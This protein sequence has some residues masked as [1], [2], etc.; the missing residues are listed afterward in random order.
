MWF[1]VPTMGA[2]TAE[3]LP[4][5]ERNLAAIG[6]RGVP[7]PTY[8]RHE[9]P[10][11]IAHIGVGGFHRAHLAVYTDEVAHGGGDWGIRGIGLLPTDAAMA[12]A[13]EPQDCL[14]SLVLKGAGTPTTSIIGSIVDYCHAA[15]R[16]DDAVELLADPVVAIVSLT[17]T[18]AGY[19]AAG[20]ASFGVIA[21]ALDRR[22]RNGDGG[23][24]VLSCDN[25]PG[26]G[27]VARRAL[28]TAA[29]RIG[30]LVGWVEERCS[31][32]N[33]MVDR[34]T[35]VT[36]DDDR[37][38]LLERE[39][40][41][42]RWPV[43]AEPFRQWV[44]EDDFVAGRPEWERAGALF[45]TDV[46]AW[47]LYKLRILNA[48]HSC[49]AY[50][51]ALAGLTFVDEA[52]A[53]PTVHAYVAKLLYDEAVPALVPIHGHPRV[54]YVSTVL[55]R[56]T[57]PGVRDQIARLCIDGTAKFPTF[58][59]PTIEH[60]LAAGGPIGCATMALAGWARYLAVVPTVE[61]AADASGAESRR[62][63]AEALEQPIRFLDL[64]QVFT[65]ALRDS[66]RFRTEFVEAA[67][68]LATNGPLSAMATAG[69][70]RPHAA[71]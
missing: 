27:D 26:N 20:A 4:V 61:Q 59:V 1:N 28:L 44:L 12:A 56:F 52:M 35:P 71:V 54:E 25:L 14:Y 15:A 48:G 63:A 5:A 53:V 45:T 24:S 29:G 55:G 8:R 19:G 7:V 37:T 46:H 70:S 41:V 43:V 3:P 42:D 30:G 22:R 65:P 13:L 62:L 2:Q 38:A 47:E 17:V 66:D 16:S 49:L 68:A 40:I 18:E 39:G 31:F 50:L 67:G 58:L 32:P 9:L 51:S 69:G 11:R 36:S 60:Q 64:E 33:S 6:A 21:T 34:I 23:V 57:N 10:P